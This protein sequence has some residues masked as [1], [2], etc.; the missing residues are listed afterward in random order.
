MYV[1]DGSTGSNDRP[2][3][4]EVIHQ[5]LDQPDNDSEGQMMV[6]L[7]PEVATLEL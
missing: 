4:F 5:L 6:Y 7:N 2:A 3:V 1:K